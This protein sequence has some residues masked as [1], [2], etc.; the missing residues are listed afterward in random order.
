MQ[1]CG[2]GLSHACERGRK[3][4]DQSIDRVRALRQDQDKLREDRRSR[5]QQPQRLIAAVTRW[6]QTVAL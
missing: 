6:S 4:P 5:P 3:A 2:S 1:V